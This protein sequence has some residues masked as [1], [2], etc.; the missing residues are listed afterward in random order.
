MEKSL[1]SF[2][3]GVTFH[4]RVRPKNSSSK[5]ITTS[6]LRGIHF[7]RSR[8]S[9]RRFRDNCATHYSGLLRYARTTTH[10]GELAR[11]TNGKYCMT[12]PHEQLN[13][14]ESTFFLKCVQNFFC[15]ADSRLRFEFVVFHFSFRARSYW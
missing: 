5:V 7:K 11:S 2:P 3:S 13:C 9:N 4:P 12:V 1:V 6:Q 8:L 14:C 15:Q 10:G